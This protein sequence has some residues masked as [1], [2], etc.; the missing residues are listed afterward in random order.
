MTAI[1][2]NAVNYAGERTL[3]HKFGTSIYKATYTGVPTASAAAQNIWDDGEKIRVVQQQN[4]LHTKAECHFGEGKIVKFDFSKETV[5]FTE[6]VSEDER[7]LIVKE[8]E[9]HGLTVEKIK[10]LWK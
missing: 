6:K 5:K 7:D 2:G 1:N 3:E 8:L 9:T 4:N 10:T